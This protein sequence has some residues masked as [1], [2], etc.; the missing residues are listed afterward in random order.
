[1]RAV[2]ECM[3]MFVLNYVLLKKKLYNKKGKMV[4]GWKQR[5]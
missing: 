4:H 2:R 3:T 5:Q 1:M